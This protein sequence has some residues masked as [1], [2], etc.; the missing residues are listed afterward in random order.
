[1]KLTVGA[2]KDILQGLDD[3]IILADLQRGNDKFRAFNMIKRLVVLQDN[4]GQKYLTIN[5][6]G[7]HFTAEGEQSH[8]HYVG[9]TFPDLT[10]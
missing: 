2:L 6:L 4:M 9:P 3:D 10:V 8:L 1:M 7:S 5:C